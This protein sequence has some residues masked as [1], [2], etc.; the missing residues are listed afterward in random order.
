MNSLEVRTFFIL[1][2]CTQQL[3]NLD[4]FHKKHLGFDLC[5]GFRLSMVFKG[6]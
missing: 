1:V 4:F 5:I 6:V 3:W 2:Y